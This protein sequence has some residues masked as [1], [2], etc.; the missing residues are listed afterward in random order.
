MPDTSQIIPI[1][2]L[3]LGLGVAWLVVRFV[4]KLAR[5]VFVLGCV[6]IVILGLIVYLGAGN[7]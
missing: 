2:M 5:R 7:L 3:I 1:V 4:F 6:G